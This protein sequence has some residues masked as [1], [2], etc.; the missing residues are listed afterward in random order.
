MTLMRENIEELPDFVELA[1]SLGVDQAVFWHMNDDDARKAENWVV[2]RD[3]WIYNYREQLTSRYPE[4]SNRMVQ[5]ATDR[6]RKLG[7]EI[8]DSNYKQLWFPEEVV[9]R[10]NAV[11]DPWGPTDCA[12]K[13]SPARGTITDVIPRMEC[14]APWRWLLVGVEGKMRACC[15][16]TG[17]LGNLKLQDPAQIWNGPQMQSLRRAIREHRLHPLCRGAACEYAHAQTHTGTSVYDQ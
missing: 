10:T 14:D 13:S 6:S 9:R 4:L 8:A 5:S 2:E 7:M 1:H 17:S 11:E 15:H 12:N 16:M 3:G